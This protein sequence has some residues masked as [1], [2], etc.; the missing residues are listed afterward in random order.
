M[1][2]YFMQQYTITLLRIFPQPV[3]ESLFS[4]PEQE[5]SQIQEYLA[6]IEYGP[7][8]IR[9]HIVLYKGML[10]SVHIPV[11]HSLEGMQNGIMLPQRAA[12]LQMEQI[13][14]Q[15]AITHYKQR[16]KME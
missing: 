4:L 14:V 6:D 12:I 10:S 2:A 3:Q 5:K 9:S 13:A 11:L 1:S 7:F 15:A 16:K 8:I